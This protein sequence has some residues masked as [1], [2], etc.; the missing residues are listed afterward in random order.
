M[1]FARLVPQEEPICRTIFGPLKDFGV[2]QSVPHVTV[3]NLG[4]QR[5]LTLTQDY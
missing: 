1:T 5:S 3:L 4:E 2:D